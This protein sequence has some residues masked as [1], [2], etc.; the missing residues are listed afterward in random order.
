MSVIPENI[1][2][3]PSIERTRSFRR[4]R[5]VEP[6]NR[7]FQESQNL[8]L[9]INRP[10][11]GY[12]SSP[13]A[14]PSKEYD[15]EHFCF[16]WNDCCSKNILLKPNILLKLE[17]DPTSSLYKKKVKWIEEKIADQNKHIIDS[18]KDNYNEKHEI[19]TIISRL[20]TYIWFAN[21][22]A[23]IKNFDYGTKSTNTKN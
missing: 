11:R 2:T 18:L 6:S 10:W 4:R 22:L 5:R 19:E 3:S 8:L 21:E 17:R 23:Q 20:K 7:S 12:F 14:D 13:N 15:P 16:N 1:I 9:T